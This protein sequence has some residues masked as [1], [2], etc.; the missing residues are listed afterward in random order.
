MITGHF[1]V[2]ALARS[3]LR[4][5]IKPWYFFL[6]LGASVSPDVADVLYWLA[7]ICSPY[8]LYSHTL[9]AVVLQAAVIGGVALLVSGSRPVAL[10]FASVVMLHM[11]GDLITGRKLFAPGAEM[12]GLSLYQAP[13]WDWALE[14]PILLLG[15]LVLRRNG[16]GPS[17]ATSVYALVAMVLLQSAFDAFGALDGRGV[18]PNA[19]PRVAPPSAMALVTMAGTRHVGAPDTPFPLPIRSS[20]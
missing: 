5:P 3:A 18:K 8:G 9:H 19:C 4:E 1:G 11:P 13:L 10:L 16:R 7:G 2:A 6:L 14:L 15:W 12:M 17:W 20:Q